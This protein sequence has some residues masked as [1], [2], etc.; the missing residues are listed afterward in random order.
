MVAVTTLAD[1]VG[2]APPSAPPSTA[3]AVLFVFVGVA[4]MCGGIVVVTDYK[5]LASLLH[6]KATS[7]RR[8][9]SPRIHGGPS[10]G[11]SNFRMFGF[12]HILGGS[13]AVAVGIYLLGK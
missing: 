11:V 4:L 5:G 10:A 13:G 9:K 1:L 12:V 6:A 7:T 2:S 8:N 3:G